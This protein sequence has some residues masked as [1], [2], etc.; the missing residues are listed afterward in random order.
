MEF[1]PE[2]NLLKPGSVDEAVT[3]YNQTPEAKYL[4]GG[5]DLLV[6]IRRGIA[7]PQT[8]VHLSG[9]EEIRAITRQDDGGLV[10][11]SGLTLEALA[12]DP[13]LQKNYPAIAEAAV[14]VAASTH[15]HVATLGGNLC[16]DTRCVY[17]NQSEWWRESNSY[18]L[19]ARGD[20]CHVAPSGD[21]CF[22]AF[23]GDVAPAII[24]CD[25]VV[26]IAGSSGRRILP[27]EQMY[28]DNGLD[29]LKLQGDE[30]LVSVILPAPNG[31][32]STYQKARVRGAIDF[33]LAGVAI[34]LKLDNA[35][36][37]NLRVALTGVNSCPLLV[38]G[39]EQFHGKP[40][41]EPAIESLVALLP[42]QIQPM[43][44]TFTPPGYRR[45]VV[46]NL[47][48]SVAGRLRSSDKS[49]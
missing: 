24:A 1:M 41:D 29:H 2:F 17:Y 30:I 39:T 14:V 23:S 9:I 22:A 48:R 43:T 6:N 45:K 36:V 5:T 8:L 3:M 21:D 37:E 10:I 15:R 44:S 27:L 13:Y 33:P 46:A 28:N 18:C 40:F 42:K 49:G 12:E 32:I 7:A 4:A 16:L 20:T 11:G 35:V 19:K 34:H 38:S 25:G 47:V 31:G 26:E